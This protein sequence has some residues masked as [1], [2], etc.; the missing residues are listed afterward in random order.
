MIDIINLYIKNLINTTQKQIL[1]Q[2]ETNPQCV[3]VVFEGGLFN[4]SYESGFMYYLKTIETLIYIKVD[5]R[6]C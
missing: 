6:K 1:K 2:Y 3:D 5:N 4:G